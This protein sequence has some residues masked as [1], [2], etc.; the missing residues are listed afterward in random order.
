[1]ANNATTTETRRVLAA[2]DGSVLGVAHPQVTEQEI[3]EERDAIVHR[4]HAAYLNLTDQMAEFQ[5]QW[6]A[7]PTMAFITAAREGWNQGGADWLS[8]QAE[9]FEKETWTALGRNIKD[10]AGSTYDR[11]ATYSKQRYENLRDELNKHIENAD[12]TIANWSWWQRV[13]ENEIDER[14][15]LLQ[16]AGAGVVQGA[17]SVLE[18]AEKAKK[19]YKHRAEIMRLPELI[20]GGDPK[21]VQ[22]FVD[23][24]LMDID[25]KLATSIK[26][27]PNFAVVLELIADHD[28]ALGY[29]A[30]VGLVTE[31]IPPNFYAYTA[32]K[33]GAYV[34][35]EVVLLLVTALLSVGTGVAARIGMLA[36]RF[37]S[38]GA[39]A[40]TAGAKLQRAQAAVQAFIRVLED[41][42]RAVEDL[43][44]FGAKLIQARSK[45]L[46]LRGS[47]R[48]TV[49][50]KRESIKR[51]KRC[52]I[53]GS[54]THS[55]PR[56]RP[57]TVKYR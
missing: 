12:D 23:T 24:V 6:D 52:R 10:F 53:C 22:A 28:S 40:A 20:A 49:H 44:A 42:A 55:T 27:D 33:G 34:A 21:P 15:A 3:V 47:T 25:P 56:H 32:G 48:T 50:A 37:A 18:S 54:T 16:S 30:Y 2:Q 51:D 4:L 13:I 43:H 46:V 26:R 17:H 9:L 14:V 29:V 19:I 45:G 11:L 38:A 39:K 41:F 8:D 1:M 5:Q 35:I 36:A 31:A 57:G 7:G